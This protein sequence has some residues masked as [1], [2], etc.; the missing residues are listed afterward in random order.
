MRTHDEE[1]AVVRRAASRRK[2]SEA[3]SGPIP[4]VLNPATILRLQREIGNAA[5]SG[6]LDDAGSDPAEHVRS[7][8]NSD[9]G[10]PLP[11]HIRAQGEEALSADLGGVRL[12]TDGAAAQ[13]ARALGAHAYTTG[14]HVVLGD[15]AYSPDSSAGQRTLLHEITHVVQQRSGPVAGTR[16]GG[17]SLSD[18]SD[19]F[20]R[21]AEASAASIMS[22][23]SPVA[24]GGGGGDSAVQRELDQEGEE[25]SVQRMSPEDEEETMG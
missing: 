7:V 17:V 4:S 10:R 1:P 22:G 11:D 18:P 9:A 24:A 16:V 20:E 5:V 3:S 15:G 14:D 19:A 6:L 13:S 23:G 25:T 8:I 21:A 12:H 2:T